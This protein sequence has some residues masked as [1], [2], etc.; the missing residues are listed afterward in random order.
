[1]YISQWLRIS[2]SY[3][4]SSFCNDDIDDGTSVKKLL[5]SSLEINFCI[6]NIWM[7]LKAKFNW[8]M[9]KNIP[10]SI[11]YDFLHFRR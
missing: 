4:L 9:K 7:T 10:N 2:E 11:V 1:M 8:L 5:L 6:T 3:I